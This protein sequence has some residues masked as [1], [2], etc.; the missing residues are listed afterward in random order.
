VRLGCVSAGQDRKRW[1]AG[2]VEIGFVLGSL[3]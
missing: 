3:S 2:G 1:G